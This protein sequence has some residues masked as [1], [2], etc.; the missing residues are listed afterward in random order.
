MFSQGAVELMFRLQESLK[1]IGGFAGVSLQPAAGAQGELAG[2]FMI[3][4][5]HVDGAIPSVPDADS[6]QRPRHQPGHLH[7]GRLRDG[8]HPQ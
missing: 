4:K 8:H 1:S 6:G 2:V 5:Y 7:H 3:R